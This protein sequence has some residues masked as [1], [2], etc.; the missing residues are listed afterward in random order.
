MATVGIIGAGLAGLAAGRELASA[1]QTVVIFEKSRG[2]GGRAATRRV[3]DFRF[4]HG[5]QY[6]QAPDPETE[7]LVAATCGPDGLPAADIGRPVWLFDAAGAIAPGDPEINA[8]PKWTWPAGL[9]ALAKA[10]GSGLDVR[11]ETT[12]GALR[13]DG[14][15]WSVLDGAGTLLGDFDALLLT[16]P[17]PQSAALLQA[18]NLDTSL[19]DFLLAELGRATYRR[20]LSIS[21][22]FD[23]RPALPWYALLNIDRGHAI[24][25]LACEHDKPGR[26]PAG[27]ALITAQM[28]DTWSTAHWDVLAK[29]TLAS[30][31]WPEPITEA[32]DLAL[33][34]IGHDPGPPLWADIQRWRYA[35]P[36]SSCD[37]TLLNGTGSGLYFAGDFLAMPGRLHLAIASGRAAAALILRK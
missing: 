28:A 10:L 6:L 37:G 15:R 36:N 32:R 34:L 22:A 8:R 2:L 35:L 29:G 19:R 27:Q 25:W 14:R 33:A 5:A 20:C 17:A 18:G 7:A 1:G 4:D 23:R 31:P 21:F 11:L 3:G 16:A 12:V 13:Q 24:S 9:T 26:A 30:E